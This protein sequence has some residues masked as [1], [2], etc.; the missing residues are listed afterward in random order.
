MKFIVK[1]PRTVS[2]LKDDIR[3]AFEEIKGQSV[4]CDNVSRSIRGRLR[5][6]VIHRG[7]KF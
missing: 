3:D 7:K 5:S 6:C 1:N 4:L 2:D